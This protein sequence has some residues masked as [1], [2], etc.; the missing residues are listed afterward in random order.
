MS[1]VYEQGTAPDTLEAVHTISY[2]II[3]ILVLILLF[4]DYIDACSM[5]GS[6]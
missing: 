3:I 1:H 5:L 4:C 2:F 6:C